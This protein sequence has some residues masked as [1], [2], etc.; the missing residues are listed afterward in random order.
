MSVKQI[1]LHITN[2]NFYVSSQFFVSKIFEIFG[3][4][5]CFIAFGYEVSNIKTLHTCSNKL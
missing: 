2:S 4:R 5:E 1:Y 3:H